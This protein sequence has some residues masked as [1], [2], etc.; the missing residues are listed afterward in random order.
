MKKICLAIPVFLSSLVLLT[1]ASFASEQITLD[2]VKEHDSPSNCWVIFEDNVYDLTN[3]IPDH[4]IY[5][6]IREWCGKDMTEDF[7]TKDGIGRDHMARSYAMLDSYYIGDLSTDIETA[8]PGEELDS[9]DEHYSVEI[10]GSEL[11]TF[12]IK[13]IADLWDI[14]AD[15]LLE[16]IIKE[17]GLKEA[18]SSENVLD[19]L[20]NENI[21][22]PSEVK[23]IA[24]NIKN[25]TILE[26]TGNTTSRIKNPYN[27]F[28]PFLASAILY[29]VSWQLTK[30]NIAKKH[31]LFSKQYFNM[32]WNTVLLIALIPSLL[33]GSIM[34]LQFQF[35]SLIDFARKLYFLHVEGSIIFGTVALL[36]LLTRLTQYLAPIKNLS[37]K[38]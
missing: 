14:N 32:I 11:K 20:R 2:E 1:Q 26:D 10:S 34:A 9:E 33:F 35:P 12:T 16:E 19:D 4:D 31:Q 18:Y 15:T 5:L 7:K 30:T 38:T 24:E 3:Y 28:L 22:T 13:E 37:K 21:F 36:H 25:G 6:D 8:E 23:V 29:L 27:F 17:F